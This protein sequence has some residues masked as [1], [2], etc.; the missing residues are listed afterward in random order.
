ML[1]GAVAVFRS[2][3]EKVL[4]NVLLYSAFL[5][6]GMLHLMSALL[7]MYNIALP[8]S[9]RPPYLLLLD[10]VEITLF[11]SLISMAM[12][13]RLRWDCQVDPKYSWLF[14]FGIVSVL[15]SFYTS[16]Y[17][18]APQLP[19]YIILVLT[20]FLTCL[21]GGLIGA[22]T[23]SVFSLQ[24]IKD[25]FDQFWMLNALLL[26]AL[27][28]PFIL[29]SIVF[30]TSFWIP[31]IIF[32]AF[33][34]ISFNLA[35]SIPELQRIG[36]DERHASLYS[37]ILSI[38][39]F[40]PFLTAF[41]LEYIIPVGFVNYQLYAT[42][43][44]GAVTISLGIAVLLLISS[45]QKKNRSLLPLVFAFLFWAIIEGALLLGSPYD[46]IRHESE[47]PYIVGYIIVF[48][49]L[50]LSVYWK[51]RSPQ[52]Q[53]MEQILWGRI[54][55]G[56]TGFLTVLGVSLGLDFYL[57]TIRPAFYMNPIDS[58]I[59]LIFSY[60][61]IFL[62]TVLGYL[63][64]KEAK[65]KITIEFLAL[66]FLMLWIIPGI[67]K[68]NF[69]MWEMGWWG[70]EFLLLGGLMIAPIIFGVAYLRALNVTEES[71]QRAMLYSDILAHD[72]SNY[73]Q[74]ILTSLELI[75]LDGLPEELLEQAIKQIYQSISR[76]DHLIKNVRRLGQAEYMPVTTLQPVDLVMCINIAFDEVSRALRKNEFTL[77]C[78]QKEKQCYVDANLLLVDL[79]QNLIRNAL[80]H[81]N[82]KKQIEI[83]IQLVNVRNKPCWEIQVIDFGDGIPPERKPLLFNRYMDGAH[84]SGLG[85]SVVH[86]LSE[87]FGGS[88]AVQD[89]VSGK[90]Q[91]GTVFSVYLPVS[92]SKI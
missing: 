17:L 91:E 48:V 55:I 28:L 86:A 32:V 81:S 76:A 8:G 50:G 62:F 35:V 11:I 23:Y 74:A 64:L 29:V 47:V 16:V 75:E 3:R 40:S 49:L 46:A 59:L 73:H 80:E 65:G 36:M 2:R 61:N 9:N 53:L 1:T 4:S 21:M 41:L 25:H 37:S 30:V 24:V 79:F 66:I 14:G 90:H 43:R 54:I 44:V 22:S 92:K 60:V 31:S 18:I 68:A 20:M 42:I 69:P 57:W 70:A 5:L 84:G 88:V 67:L 13:I 39:A 63:F 56:V 45:K 33:A 15:F 12:L 19:Y 72:I 34:L 83:K 26:S 85:L 82:T 6:F 38:F 78:N 58:T 89:R 27:A 10:L 52:K 7:Q 77:K 51:H 87:A 71:E